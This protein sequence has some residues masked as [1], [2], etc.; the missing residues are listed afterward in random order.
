MK[1]ICL[2]ESCGKLFVYPSVLTVTINQNPTVAVSNLAVQGDNQQTHVCP[3]CLSPDIEE[4]IP[5]PEPQPVEEIQNVYIYD[6]TTG[7]QTALDQLLAQGYQIVNRYSKQYH[8]EKPKAK[9]VEHKELKEI[10]RDAMQEAKP[11]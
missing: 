9:P 3:Y 10:I 11:Q 4:Y 8:L 7:P 1:F 6:L 2:N 5:A